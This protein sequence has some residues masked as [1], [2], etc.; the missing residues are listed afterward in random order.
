[1][2]L[3]YDVL[4]CYDTLGWCCILIQCHEK[5][6]DDITYYDDIPCYDDVHVWNVMLHYDE[7]LSDTQPQNDVINDECTR[8]YACMLPSV[9]CEGCVGLCNIMI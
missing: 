8:T 3:W 1:M 6:D 9:I 4:W 7:K 2:L 5:Y